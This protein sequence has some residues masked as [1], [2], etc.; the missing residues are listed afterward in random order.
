MPES[1]E[2][3][4]GCP[5][6]YHRRGSGTKSAKLQLCHSGLG[7]LCSWLNLKTSPCVQL[8][9]VGLHVP[10]CWHV[11]FGVPVKFVWHRA[12]QV[13]PAYLVLA[14]LKVPL[15][16]LSGGVVHSA[17]QAKDAAGEAV[18]GAGPASTIT[19]QLAQLAANPCLAVL[20]TTRCEL[21]TWCLCFIPGNAI[22][23]VQI[24]SHPELVQESGDS[25]QT[26]QPTYHEGMR[27]SLS[28][29]CL[30]PGRCR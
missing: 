12:V 20:P 19:T 17:L 21:P 8:P 6:K 26:Q 22:V 29:S 9:V 16:G 27:Q 4:M 5:S 2:C 1:L 10:S 23:K 25:I 28:T 14:Q 11:V 18:G 3:H 15:A 24:C 30:L 13:R 7:K